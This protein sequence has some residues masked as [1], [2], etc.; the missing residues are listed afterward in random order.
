MLLM[1]VLV[2]GCLYLPIIQAEP[3]GQEVTKPIEVGSTTRWEVLARFGTPKAAH[4]QDRVL[5]H[6]SHQL[7]GVLIIGGPYQGTAIPLSKRYF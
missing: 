4:R 3:F 2:S 7:L 1:P 5:V 6:R